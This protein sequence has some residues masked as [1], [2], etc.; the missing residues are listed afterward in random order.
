M[1]VPLYLYSSYI[2][3]TSIASCRKKIAGEIK[4]ILQLH[5]FKGKQSKG[6]RVSDITPISRRQNPLRRTTTPHYHSHSLCAVVFRLSHSLYESILVL[7]FFCLYCFDAAN[8]I[9]YGKILTTRP[10]IATKC[11]EHSASLP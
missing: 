4:R 9:R 2:V 8:E 6:V 11:E 1:L 5:L 7:Y 10:N 3:G